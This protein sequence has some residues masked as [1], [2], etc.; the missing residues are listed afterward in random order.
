MILSESRPDKGEP[1]KRFI[2]A[3]MSPD[4]R[5]YEALKRLAERMDV[6]LSWLVC[7]AG[8][9]IRDRYG[10]NGQ[11]ELALRVAEKHAD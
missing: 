2:P 3:T 10:T 7:R 11:P 1:G 9:E 4:R 5:D 6:S 8:R